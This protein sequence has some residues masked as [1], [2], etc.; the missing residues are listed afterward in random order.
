MLRDSKKQKSEDAV[1]NATPSTEDNDKADTGSAEA[2]KST[3]NR[4]RNIIIGTIIYTLAALGIASHYCT[5]SYNESL[6]LRYKQYGSM[7][8]PCVVLIPGLD[9]VT[10]FFNVRLNG[11]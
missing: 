5:S 2:K 3:S 8:K 7:D 11:I 1:I 6:P 4:R 10:S 9:G